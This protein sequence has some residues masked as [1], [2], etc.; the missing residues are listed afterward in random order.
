MAVSH[1]AQQSTNNGSCPASCNSKP[2]DVPSPKRSD[3]SRC[4]QYHIPGRCSPQKVA[5]H[6]VMTLTTDQNLDELQDPDQLALWMLVPNV[7]PALIID[8][9]Q[10]ISPKKTHFPLAS[11]SGLEAKQGNQ[12]TTVTS[13]PC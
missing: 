5:Q 3:R 6:S 10:V 7:Q 8:E 9:P 11:R 4:S 1:M 2:K 13:V 12:V